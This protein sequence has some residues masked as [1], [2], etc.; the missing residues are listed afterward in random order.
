MT[1]K[2]VPWHFSV[3]NRAPGGFELPQVS[4][5]SHPHSSPSLFLSWSE[6][7]PVSQKAASHS[8][9]M[10]SG[11]LLNTHG[12]LE[13]ALPGPNPNLDHFME[14]LLCVGQECGS[15]DECCNTRGVRR[16]A[17]IRL[18]KSQSFFLFS[19]SS[20]QS[21]H[22]SSFSIGDTACEKLESRV[23]QRPHA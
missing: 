8:Q 19:R 18:L 10:C 7:T 22:N 23:V 11:L 2:N 15:E 16:P 14:L 17:W 20:F 4:F 3:I 13:D 9:P 21:F 12:V 1:A 5:A 6:E